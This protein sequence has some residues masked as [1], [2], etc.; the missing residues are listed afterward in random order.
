MGR[1]S[2]FLNNS[3]EKRL[4][5][6]CSVEGMSKSELLR[7]IITF[8][9][10]MFNVENLLNLENIKVYIMLL[11]KGEHL[12]IDVAHWDLFMGISKHFDDASWQEL[13]KI[14]REHGEQWREKVDF[15]GFLKLLECCNWFSIV[16]MNDTKY[17]L[18]PKTENSI[19]FI[20]G[21]LEGVCEGYE[22]QPKMIKL[23]GKIL[24]KL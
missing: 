8:Y 24:I 18:I 2:V 21:F 4:E 16:K 12:I 17:I 23:K 19:D 22:I 13:N 15:I 3:C 6:L 9:Y 11:S 10:E 20:T 14:G 5:L 1:H 7:K